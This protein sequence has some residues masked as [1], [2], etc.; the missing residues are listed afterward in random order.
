[1]PDESKTIGQNESEPWP[2]GWWLGHEAGNLI[3]LKITYIWDTL[4][5]SLCKTYH[6]AQ[7]LN[8]APPLKMIFF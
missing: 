8:R 4:D 7:A 1:M 6:V 2:R 5:Y 3:P